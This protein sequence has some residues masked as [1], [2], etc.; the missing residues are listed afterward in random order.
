MV[1]RKMKN[2]FLKMSTVH[3]YNSHNIY[4]IFKK[5]LIR[6]N[7]YEKYLITNYFVVLTTNRECTQFVLELR[8]SFTAWIS[9]PTPQPQK[10]LNPPETGV[11][12]GC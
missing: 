7:S 6:A 10:F 3:I 2:C 12:N 1:V 11:C 5:I 4:L 8:L 9:S